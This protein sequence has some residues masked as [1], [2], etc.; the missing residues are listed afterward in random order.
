[1]TLIDIQSRDEIAAG[2]YLFHTPT[3]QLVI[4]GQLPAD[5]NTS[6][7]K[8]LLRGHAIEDELENFKKLQLTPE[9]SRRRRPSG[10]SGCKGK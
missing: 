6:V 4:C 8:A 2:E 9:E 7:I 10:C 3:S 5:P 1:M